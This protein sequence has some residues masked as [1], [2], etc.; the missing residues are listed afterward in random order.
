MSS[1]SRENVWVPHFRVDDLYNVVTTAATNVRTTHNIEE[2]ATKKNFKR[3][4]SYD[5]YLEEDGGGSKLDR[6]LFNHS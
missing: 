4:V 6:E 2:G 3:S 5:L 1:V